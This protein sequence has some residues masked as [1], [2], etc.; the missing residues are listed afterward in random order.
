MARKPKKK[1]QETSGGE[2]RKRRGAGKSDGKG[3]LRTGEYDSG[4]RDDDGLPPRED[5]LKYIKTAGNTVGKREIS[6][7]FSIKGDTRKAFKRLLQEMADDGL[8]SGN[9]SDIREKGGLPSVAVLEVIGQD[10]SGD[11]IAQPAVWKDEDGERPRVLILTHVPEAKN[12]GANLAVGDRVLCRIDQLEEPDVEGLRFEAVP[13]RKLPREKQR[14]LGIFRASK[15]GGG[16]IEPID[17]KSLRSWPVQKSDSGKAGDGDLVRYDLLRKGR[18]ATPQASVLEVL[19]NPDDQRQISLIAVHAHGIPDD[20]PESVIAEA[21]S[22]ERAKP[23]Q[24]T[25]LTEL[26]L[27]TIDPPDARDHDDAVF[28]EPDTDENNPGGVVVYVAI[29][30]VAHNVR[31]GSRL[32]REARKRGNSVY[33]PDRVVPMLPERIS[34]DLCSLREGALRACLAVRMVFNKRGEKRQHAFMRAMMRSHAKLAYQEAQDAIDGKPTDK[35]GALLDTVLK[36]LWAAYE[37]VAAARDRRGPLDLDLPERKIIL[38]KD[39][40][41]DRVTVPER[42][43]AHRL[44]EE[45]MIQ[46]N[47]AAAETLESKKAPVVYRVH[48][49]PSKEKLKA[50]REFLET[51]G[52]KLPPQNQLRPEAF[53]GILDKAK[54]LPVTDLINEVVLRSQSQAVYSPENAGHFGL[55][56]SRYAHFTSPIRRYADLLVHRSLIRSLGLGDDGLEASEVGQLSAISEQISEAER[57]A[58]SAERETNDRLIAAHLADRIGADF[59]AR[60]SGVTRSGVFVRLS[61]T[62]ADGFVPAA[63]LGDEYYNYVEEAH[64]MIGQRSGL[65]YSLGDTVDVRLV[66]AIPTAGALRFEMLSEP[67]KPTGRTLPKGLKAPRGR[68]RRTGGRSGAP[69]RRRGK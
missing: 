43:A 1:P 36:P 34:N 9:R 40:R 17:R 13:I 64:A 29:A 20:F 45:F 39:G 35:A 41:V 10:H 19:G 51:L 25:D 48:E 49:P 22:L 33:F 14:L 61:E 4:I 23:G 18:F 30:D 66:E 53:N 26:P 46:A 69:K 16:T 62:G 12:A 8:I 31:P 11:L 15:K 27:I 54:T 6:R 2:S 56:L 5:I 37:K 47:V 42:L 67:R 50:L 32:D 44:I 65:S 58:M 28:A 60:I 52:M 63:S 7:A 59:S 55:N 68:G 3:Y 24:R 21:E 57:R 38:D